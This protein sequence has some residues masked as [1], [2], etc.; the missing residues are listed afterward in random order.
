ME[1]KKRMA[2]E[3][4]KKIAKGQE[5]VKKDLKYKLDRIRDLEIARKQKLYLKAKEDQ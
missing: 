3:T 5:R 2:V 4:E 1:V